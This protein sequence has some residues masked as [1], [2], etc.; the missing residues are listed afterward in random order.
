MKKNLLILLS[1]LV[2]F[3]TIFSKAHA[4]TLQIYSQRQS[5]LIDPILKKFTQ[6]TNIDIEIVDIGKALAQRLIAEGHH[7]PVDV[8]LSNGSKVL[9]NLSRQD[10]LKTITDEDII[11]N[12][13]KQFRGMK[14]EWV[15]LTQR[16]RIIVVKK[17]LIDAHEIAD[18]EDLANQKWMG[19]ICTRKGSHSYNRALLSSIIT[20]HGNDF[21]LDWAKK[22]VSN[23]ARRPQGND[24]AQAK[25]IYE[26]EC[27]IALMNSYYFGLM[28]HG[29]KKD[30]QQAWANKVNMVFPNQ[31]NRG[32][33]VNITGAAISKYTNN[34]DNAV[35]L[36]QFLTSEEGQALYSALNY[37]YPVNPKASLSPVTRS[38]GKFV[39][40]KLPIETIEANSGFA[41]MI[42]NEADW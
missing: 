12:I 20:H 2:I 31:K 24:R 7:T 40:D 18:Y 38:W 36:L 6:K 8:I 32:T 28:L 19:K 14:N 35:K 13:P 30:E 4:E 26:G 39:A 11:N 37:E 16:A 9:Y 34:Y 33:H 27:E 15:A 41:Q 25:A 3:S 1:V 10:L 5:V 22:L 29:N 42:I 17:E 21:A 23:M